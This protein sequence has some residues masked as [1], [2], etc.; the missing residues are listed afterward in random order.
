MLRIHKH[1][2]SPSDM[3]KALHSLKGWRNGLEAMDGSVL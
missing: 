3:A 2:F 1:N